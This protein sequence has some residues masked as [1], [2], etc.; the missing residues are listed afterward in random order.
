MS[1]IPE[2]HSNKWFTVPFCKGQFFTSQKSSACIVRGAQP[3]SST[4]DKKSPKQRE[5]IRLPYSQGKKALHDMLLL[6]HF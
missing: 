3:D 5:K 2:C 4:G 1:H 6:E